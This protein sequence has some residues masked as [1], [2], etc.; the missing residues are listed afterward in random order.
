M[1]SIL[2]YGKLISSPLTRQ[3]I[4]DELIGVQN[5]ILGFAGYSL[6]ILLTLPMITVYLIE[7]LSFSLWTTGV[8]VSI[9]I[10]LI[11]Y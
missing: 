7:F 4:N 11:N 9:Y 10:L 8:S 3:L 6:N 5:R 2:E 1:R